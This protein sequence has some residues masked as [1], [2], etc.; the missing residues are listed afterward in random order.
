MLII[1]PKLIPIRFFPHLNL[2]ILYNTYTFPHTEMVTP[3]I[4]LSLA[5]IL[6]SFLH[7]STP[8]HS[9]LIIML[10]TQLSLYLSIQDHLASPNLPVP[11]AKLTRCL[12]RKIFFPPNSIPYHR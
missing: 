2:T 6:T 3:S 4:Y 9:F 7:P 8:F 11:T 5:K 12:S 10:H 1:L